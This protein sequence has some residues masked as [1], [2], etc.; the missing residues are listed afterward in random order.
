MASCK[1]DTDQTQKCCLTMAFDFGQSAH[2]SSQ[3]KRGIPIEM[4]EIMQKLMLNFTAIHTFMV[5]Y[6]LAL[7]SVG[8]RLQLDY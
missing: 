4:L 5:Q 6:F 8:N 7:M 3:V 2:L 1:D